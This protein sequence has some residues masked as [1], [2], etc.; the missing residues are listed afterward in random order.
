MAV[1]QNDV[2]FLKNSTLCLDNNLEYK[3]Y[4]GRKKKGH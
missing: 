4:I 1:R 2:T 3:I